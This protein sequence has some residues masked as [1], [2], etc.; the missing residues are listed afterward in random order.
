MIRMQ[1]LWVLIVKCIVLRLLHSDGVMDDL[2][3]NRS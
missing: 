2:Y 1:T 3:P